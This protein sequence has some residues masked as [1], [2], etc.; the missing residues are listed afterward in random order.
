MGARRKT[1]PSSGRETNDGSRKPPCQVYT[2]C[3]ICVL[4]KTL[5]NDGKGHSA[6]AGTHQFYKKRQVIFQTGTQP[7]GL[8]VV[9]QGRVKVFKTTASGRLLTTRIASS[10]ELLGY[11]A[12]FANEPYSANAETLENT[13]VRFFDRE[14]V[15][16]TILGEPLI[17]EELLR[18]LCLE[19]RYSENREADLL[20]KPARER[21]THLLLRLGKLYATGP[22]DKNAI[23][24]LTR[25][26][27]A[28]MLGM[29]PET[30]IRILKELQ[31]NGIVRS[32]GYGQIQVNLGSL[33]KSLQDTD[34][35]W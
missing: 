7:Y 21:L 6:M 31:N 26:E 1:P 3:A 15:R 20:Y 10:G 5:G 8:Y 9:C 11:R 17:L 12:F 2:S 32:E 27:M 4:G 25:D 24:R 16:K 29:T 18:K 23:V 19:L 13:T 22:A 30:T 33:Q 34:L 28:D 35:D 14:L